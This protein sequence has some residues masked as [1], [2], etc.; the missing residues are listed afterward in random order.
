MSAFFSLYFVEVGKVIFSDV[1][2]RHNS[3]KGN[4]VSSNA[5]LLERDFGSS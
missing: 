3:R 1:S 4:F 5:G 2:Q